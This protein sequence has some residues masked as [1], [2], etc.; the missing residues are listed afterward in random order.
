MND[1]AAIVG[2]TVEAPTACF[3]V[4]CHGA[5][6]NQAMLGAE[7]GV[8]S[9]TALEQLLAAGW[10]RWSFGLLA[11]LDGVFALELRD[12]DELLLYRDPSGLQNLYW[13]RRTD[14]AVAVANQLRTLATSADAPPRLAR[15]SLHEY[16]RFLEVA[17]PHTLLQD[18]CSLEAGQ[19][20]RF[21]GH[22]PATVVHLPPASTVHEPP[23][24]SA[25]VDGLDEKLS[26]SV[27]VRLN[28]AMRP[29]A[30]LSGGV[31][32]ALLCAMAAR[33]RKDL[34]A[35][36]VGFEGAAYDESPIAQRIGEHIG[37]AHEVLRF[38]RAEFLGAFE[39]L[40]S[41]AEQPMA[42]PAAMATLLAFE[43]CRDRFDV[44]L[45]GTG[46]DELL[47]AMPPRHVRF[48]VGHAS[49]LPTNIRRYALSILRAT[50]G[51]IEYSPVLDF[52]H[53]ADTMSRWHGFTR[54]E[55][56]Q[57]CG[58][59]VSLEHTQFLRTYHRFPRH[60]HFERYSALLNAM[61]CDRLNQAMLISSAIIRFPFWDAEID[62][63]IRRLRIDH[64]YLPG[65][66]KRILR[67]LLARYVPTKLWDMP[68]HGFS[69]PLQEFLAGDDFRLVR[70][71]LLPGIW[72]EY[73]L[74]NDQRVQHY[75]RQFMAGNEGV[76]FRVWA[77]VVL[78]AWLER[79]KNR[80]DLST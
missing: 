67:S 18:V 63:C 9:G 56:E 46:A 51:L 47:G 24:F 26:R 59:P 71:H 75:G 4:V 66:P 78:G 6:L 61:T 69:F 27:Q 44:V 38:T 8:P 49:R 17:P 55:I 12:G 54:M 53:P 68:K 13:Q 73:G 77:L 2:S 43:Y 74:L 20:L 29:A 15:R 35:V 60:A 32:S 23:S 1:A 40:S 65:Q 11:R 21:K 58:E 48:A 36:T 25:A 22:Q 19:A 31:D 16:L 76:T 80:L 70:E 39:R 64:R 50:P 33:A 28:G 62:Q 34:T 7:L 42:D 45:D 72:R 37:I 10:Q 3:N 5:I 30:F 57:L 41:E 79:N 14:G 52:D